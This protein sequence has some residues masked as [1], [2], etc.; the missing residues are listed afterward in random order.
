MGVQDVGMNNV[1][2]PEEMPEI[3]DAGGAE[4]EERPEFISERV[5]ESTFAMLTQSSGESLLAKK[6]DGEHITQYL[7]ASRENMQ[8]GFQ[9]RKE[10]K[11]FAG[12]MIVIALAF[13]L[14]L[15]SML[16]DNETLLEKIVYAVIGLITGAFGGY[17]VGFKKGSSN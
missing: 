11:V 17:G 12:V 2:V 5:F 4:S 10:N 3:V 9:E 13:F 6:I 7:D 1:Q 14:V 16:K 15:I 8:K